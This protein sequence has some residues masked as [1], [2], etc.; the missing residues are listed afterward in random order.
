MKVGNKFR[1]VNIFIRTREWVCFGSSSQLFAFLR[2]VFLFV[3]VFEFEGR[4]RYLGTFF[5][6]CANF[7]RMGI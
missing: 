5:L 3:F 6:L 2:G 4:N 1:R 7:V